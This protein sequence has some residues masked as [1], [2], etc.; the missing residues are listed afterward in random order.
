[1]EYPQVTPQVTPQV[2]PQVTINTK[3]KLIDIVYDIYRSTTDYDERRKYCIV[4][5]PEFVNEYTYIFEMLCKPRFNFDKFLEITYNLSTHSNKRKKTQTEQM[6]KKR[7]YDTF[8]SL[9]C[10]RESNKYAITPDVLI[11]QL[12]HMFH[13]QKNACEYLV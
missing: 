5:Y 1:M 2:I 11:P 4:K 9:S 6:C 7:K 13:D 8:N 3:S 12:Q 10:S